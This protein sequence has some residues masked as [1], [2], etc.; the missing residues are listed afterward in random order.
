MKLA[1]LSAIASPYFETARP[2][3]PRTVVGYSARGSYGWPL[4]S[5]HVY[6]GNVRNVQF[7]GHSYIRQGATYV[8]DGQS[9]ALDPER[10]GFEAYAQQLAQEPAHTF[11]GE[12]LFIGG[13]LYDPDPSHGWPNFGHF[14]FEYVSRLAIFDRY[15]LLDRPAFVYQTIPDR[16]MDF[17]RLAGVGRF[18]LIDPERPPRYENTWTTSCPMQ[19]APGNHYYIWPPAVHWLRNRLIRGVDTRKRRRV[20]LGRGNAKWRHIANEAE[21]LAA[22]P[23]FDIMNPAALTAAEQVKWM[24]EAEVVVC[25]TGAGTI[26]TQFCPED[27]KIVVF[28]PQGSG[29]MWGGWGHAMILGQNYTMIDGPTVSNG[30]GRLNKSGVDETADYVVPIEQLQRALA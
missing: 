9:F 23:G 22:L 27:C 1:P 18:T 4:G 8:V 29:G 7:A 30:S 15:D 2:V 3:A 6:C 21:V 26:I 28:R 5:P 11:P 24:A 13:S 20:Y 16:W 10:N 25:A 19:R 17:L 14:M 12:H